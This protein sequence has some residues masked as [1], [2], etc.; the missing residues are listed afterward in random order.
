MATAGPTA[1]RIPTIPMDEGVLILQQWL[2]PGYPVGAFAYSHGLEQAV[3]EGRVADAATLAVWLRDVLEHGSGWAD[4][5]LLHAAHAGDA[6]AAPAARAFAASAGRLR[7]TLEQGAAF[8]RVTGAVWGAEAEPCAYPVAVGRA[9]RSRGLPATLTAA[10]YLQ[11]F[12]ANLV[13]AAQRLAPIGQ[14]EAMAVLALL[15]PPCA[16]IASRAGE[17]GLDALASAAYLSDIAAM[18]HEGKAVKVFRT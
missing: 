11:S 15:A 5:V 12:A 6:E 7:E 4:A 10:M 13:A 18:R 1:T 3:A 17:A 9:A 8:A 2:S 14:T 16:V